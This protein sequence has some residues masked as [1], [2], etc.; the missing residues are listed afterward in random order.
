MV[1][2]SKR[3]Q[4]DFIR[5][6]KGLLNWKTTNLQPRMTYAEVVNYR[7]EIYIKCLSITDLEIHNTPNYA[8]HEKFGKYV[9]TYKRNTRTTW[10]IIYDVK[11]NGDILIK[12][13]MNNYLTKSVSTK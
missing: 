7:N 12:K 3:S 6:F 9:L 2:Y 13:I 5:I 4:K 8:D 10:Y 11:R 1:F